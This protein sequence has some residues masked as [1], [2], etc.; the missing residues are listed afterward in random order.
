MFV[1]LVNPEDWKLVELAVILVLFTIMF[2]YLYTHFI[3]I[4]LFYIVLDYRYSLCDD[5]MDA[6]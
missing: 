5:T 2:L 1:L 6:Y 4:P 3:H